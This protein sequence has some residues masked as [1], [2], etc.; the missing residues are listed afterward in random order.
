MNE[1]LSSTSTE[2][3]YAYDDD[4]DVIENKGDYKL[5]LK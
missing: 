1:Y 5:S 2:E 4:K 3:Y